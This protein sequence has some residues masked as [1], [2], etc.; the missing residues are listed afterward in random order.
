ML[1]PTPGPGPTPGFRTAGPNKGLVNRARDILIQPKPEWQVIDGEASTIGGI[2]TGYVVILAAIPA[3]A[4]AVGLL[5]F[6]FGFSGTWTTRIIIGAVVHYLLGLAAVYVLALIIDAL[7]PTFNSTKN[8]LNAFKVAAY[9]G[10]PAWLAGAL[11]IIPGL[12][13]IALI[14]GG[15]YSLYL[16][17]LGLPML[18]R[19]PQDKAVPYVVATIVAYIVIAAV[20][21]Q[22]ATR[23]ML[24]GLYF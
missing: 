1:E 8:Q 7:A 19:T 2:Y 4:M 20:V 15:A 10:T 13:F 18:M 11:M 23:V 3:V 9:S 24:G 22:I 17:F 12:G 5:L 6:G 21:S 14:V 16:L